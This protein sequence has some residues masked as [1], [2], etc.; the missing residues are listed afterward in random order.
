MPCC[1][2]SRVSTQVSFAAHRSVRVRAQVPQQQTSTNGQCTS[3]GR[4][5][6]VTSSRRA[7]IGLVVSL[8]LIMGGPA[9]ATTKAEEMEQMKAQIEAQKDMLEYK[10]EQQRLARRAEAESKK[11]LVEEKTREIEEQI[12]LR[13][14]ADK[15]AGTD[16]SKEEIAKLEEAIAEIEKVKAE[17]E[18]TIQ[19]EEILEEAKVTEKEQLIEKEAREAE[20]SITKSINEFLSRVDD[21]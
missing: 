14:T 17:T 12:K 15:A 6:N 18:N 20:E 10:L 5:L 16:A 19:R 11:Q 8:P 9:I 4:W 7:T 3:E 13:I 1:R 2:Y 21:M